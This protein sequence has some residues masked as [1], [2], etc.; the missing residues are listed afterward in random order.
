MAIYPSRV[1]LRVPL[2]KRLISSSILTML[3]ILTYFILFIVLLKF[4]SY[5]VSRMCVV[6]NL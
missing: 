4:L 1:A 5:G 6:I 3:S 2:T